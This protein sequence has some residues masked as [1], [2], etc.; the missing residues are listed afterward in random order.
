M[1][2]K[3]KIECRYRYEAI[4]DYFSALIDS[5][6]L[7]DGEQLPSQLQAASDFGVSLPTIVRAYGVLRDQG[8]AQATRHGTFVCAPAR[9]STA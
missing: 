7:K 5:G 1:A 2:R 3:I 6:R 9:E 4:A 8:L